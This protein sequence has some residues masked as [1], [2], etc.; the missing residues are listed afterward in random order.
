MRQ[1]FIVIYTPYVFTLSLSV[2]VQSS[3]F[4]LFV[5]QA[6][7]SFRC[8]LKCRLINKVRNCVDIEIIV[9]LKVAKNITL[10]PTM[11]EKVFEF[12]SAHAN[13]G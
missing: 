2:A 9:C 10:L 5:I 4:V 11:T 1:F 6:L 13:E 12:M 3:S 8:I 7:A